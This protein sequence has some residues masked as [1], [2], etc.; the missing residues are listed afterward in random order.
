M[1]FTK[2]P[3]IAIAGIALFG[4][5]VS[6]RNDNVGNGTEV[7]NNGAPPKGSSVR[8]KVTGAL[9]MRNSLYNAKSNSK[10]FVENTPTGPLAEYVKDCN[11]LVQCTAT[12]VRDKAL[13]ENPVI[14]S[15]AHCDPRF[16]GHN[17]FPS[18]EPATNAQ[19]PPGAIPIPKTR[20]RFVDLYF[21]LSS[22]QTWFKIEDWRNLPQF[23]MSQQQ[24][25]GLRFTVAPKKPFKLWDIGIGIIA[26]NDLG[27]IKEGAGIEKSVSLVSLTAPDLEKMQHDLVRESDLNEKTFTTSFDR[28]ILKKFPLAELAG[29]GFKN[30]NLAQTAEGNVVSHNTEF[31]SDGGTLVRSVF[32]RLA[33]ADPANGAAVFYA[34]GK[35]KFFDGTL[36]G[37][38]QGDSGGPAFLGNDDQSAQLFA[39]ESWG[40]AP[41]AGSH[42]VRT[43]V[44]PYISELRKLLEK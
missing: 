29:H 33:Y 35:E 27:K 21:Y 42:S 24:R 1:V 6:C 34:D 41:C 3:E 30:N 19:L 40:G 22:S 15:A 10:C 14:L 13:S 26:K 11:F 8:A 25:P 9:V 43:L 44:A 16:G 23:E 5:L 2:M 20:M 39:V 28:S 38:C 7:Q 17:P 36:P 32:L 18:L 37:T 31:N 12:L 4:T